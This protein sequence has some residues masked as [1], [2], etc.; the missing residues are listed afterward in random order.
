MV[1]PIPA[2]LRQNLA[3]RVLGFDDAPFPTNPRVQYAEVN[4]VGI[5]TTACRFE[6]MLYGKLGQ[7]SMDATD[8]LCACVLNSKFIDQIH[9]ILTDGITMG[10][11]NVIDIE[12]LPSETER[13][14]VAVMRRQPAIESMLAACERLDESSERARRIGSAGPVFERGRWIFQYRCP[15]G[16]G[17]I[18][19][20]D[21]IADLLDRCTP[22]EQQK[23]PEQVGPYTHL[24]NLLTHKALQ[25]PPTRAFNRCR[26][27]DR[28]EFIECMNW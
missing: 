7:D 13:P 12:R 10:G 8:Q 14:E 25:V 17:D 9:C 22:V 21:D 28:T 23:I 18:P 2:L 1:K 5:V 16:Y 26:S 6:G 11:L 24:N 19:T 3:P 4:F 27:Q 20:S 15:P